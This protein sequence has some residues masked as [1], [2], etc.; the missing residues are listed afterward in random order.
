MAAVLALCGGKRELRRGQDKPQD[1][2]R[3]QQDQ[4]EPLQHIPDLSMHSVRHI[5]A[6]SD[7]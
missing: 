3:F 5:Q 7:L 2:G 1:R 4:H 6:Q